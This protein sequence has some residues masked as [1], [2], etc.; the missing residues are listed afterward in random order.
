MRGGG[1]LGSDREAAAA[2]AAT[3]GVVPVSCCGRPSVTTRHPAVTTPHPAGTSWRTPVVDDGPP[4]GDD[5]TL[6]RDVLAAGSGRLAPAGDPVWRPLVTPPL[7]PFVTTWRPSVIAWHLSVAAAVPAMGGGA[8]QSEMVE[9]TRWAAALAAKTAFSGRV[10]GAAAAGWWCSCPHLCLS[11]LPY[12]LPTIACACIFV[13]FFLP[14]FHARD[15]CRDE[16]RHS[17][18]CGVDPAS[19]RLAGRQTEAHSDG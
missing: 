17:A 19:R 16:W 1:G 13:D 10:R 6:R 8:G 3:M 4:V 7:C 15:R 18:P 11:F 12:F 9:G 14:C 5:A 2:T